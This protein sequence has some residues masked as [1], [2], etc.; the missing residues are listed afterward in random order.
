M[1]GRGFRQLHARGVLLAFA[2]MLG[3]IGCGP[4]PTA[5]PS[6]SRPAPIGSASVATT[7]PVPETVPMC[8]SSGSAGETAPVQARQLI[9]WQSQSSP[10]GHRGGLAVSADGVIAV[11]STVSGLTLWSLEARTKLRAVRDASTGDLSEVGWRGETVVAHS[12]QRQTVDVGRDGAVAASALGR[13]VEW[14]QRPWG[15]EAM[16]IA[17]YRQGF[18]QLR[19]GDKRHALELP[20]SPVYDFAVSPDDAFA[21][22]FGDGSVYVW[23]LV[24]GDAKPLAIDPALRPGERIR[25][26]A[27][28]PRAD[29]LLVA[30]DAPM[31]TK[32]PSRTLLAARAGTGWVVKE[33]TGPKEFLNDVVVAPD[34]KSALAVAYHEMVAFKLP[35]GAPTWRKVADEI[36]VRQQTWSVERNWAHARFGRDG[37][38]V[39]V[40]RVGGALEVI[41]TRTGR[42]QGALGAELH[43]AARAVFVGKDTIAA[44]GD[45]R[46]VLWSARDG[47]V[48][49]AESIPGIA[50]VVDGDLVTTSFDS[51]VVPRVRTPTL[52]PTYQPLGVQVRAVRWAGTRPPASETRP[53]TLDDDAT[54]E[55]EDYDLAVLTRRRAGKPPPRLFPPAPGRAV[56]ACFPASMTLALER[57]R[58]VVGFVDVPGRSEQAAFL[59]DLET[60]KHVE[61][62]DLHKLSANF[63]SIS[64]DGAYVAGVTGSALGLNNEL[65]VW[66]GKTGKIVKR[67]A[68][69]T[70]SAPDAPPIKGAHELFFAPD[71]KRVLVTYGKDVVLYALP[72]MREEA[73]FATPA[74]VRATR[75]LDPSGDG[76]LLG[77]SDG[78]LARAKGGKIE[79]VGAADGA[80]IATIDIN[81]DG[82][83]AAAVTVDGAIE[84]WDA[85]TATL[86]ATLASFDDDEYVA[87]TPAGA[88]AGTSEVSQRVGWVFDAPLEAFRFEQFERTA[89]RPDV[90]ARRL[91]GATEDIAPLAA[92]PPRVTVP[93]RPPP[94]VKEGSVTIR[95]RASASTRVDSVRAFV[96]GRPA[97]SRAVCAPDGDV[98][99]DVPLAPGPN[100]ITVVAFDERGLASN[101]TTLDVE[102]ADEGGAPRPKLF[103][104]AAGVSRYPKLEPRFQ[105]AVADADARA[106]ASAFARQ[107][108]GDKPFSALAPGHPRV[109]VDEQ[110][111]PA[112]LDVALRDL[113]EMKPED[114][115]VVFLAGHGVK[116][117]A[118]AEMV[119]LTATASATSDGLKQGGIAWKALGTR[120][121]AA[122][123]RVLVLLDAC[124]SGDVSKELLVPSGDLAAALSESRRA[125][126]L[127]L[128]AS[129]GRQVSYEAGGA[130]SRALVLTNDVAPLVKHAANER[131]GFF[132][133]AL[134]NALDAPATDRN[135]DGAL[136]LSE[137]VDEVT[138]RVGVASAGRQTPWVA[139]RELFGDFTVARARAGPS[140]VQSR[141]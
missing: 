133:G 81:P 102:R 18:K 101:E 78:S 68:Q 117:S 77:L 14:V 72:G 134:L 122:K 1:T 118:D 63:P 71:G 125:G 130:T 119:F 82:S 25:H 88:Y 45:G 67:G 140:S 24:G 51:C 124:H 70:P 109:L 59:V 113:A 115:A 48:E 91:A 73:R 46:V 138:A 28:G 66:D 40:A 112:S 64:P 2:F 56:S 69:V 43:R 104:V 75:A 132:T 53:P 126:V 36:H 96:E 94:R 65:V 60:T 87:F 76:W 55:P 5:R 30:V 33:L 22:A 107:V 4:P 90:V 129:K 74:V 17:T 105:L 26:V 137:I 95:A 57:A 111:T 38:R 128:A 49:R 61:L 41:D 83:L 108:G 19:I 97:A 106:I 29:A 114:F 127:V 141:E 89:R 62:E 80:T 15:P 42:T 12:R 121:A 31:A 34:G 100:R 23:P 16:P 98:T 85:K 7:P 110:V 21:S 92:R 3:F 131:H 32:Y 79:A 35:G 39:V 135:D 120:L 116:P 99:L 8:P 37:A 139:R 103:V 13:D 136:Q 27:L 47:R 6:S 11:T 54:Q 10:E 9:Q 20:A 58:A 52:S 123:G 84:V 86:R 50:T 44:S 93:A